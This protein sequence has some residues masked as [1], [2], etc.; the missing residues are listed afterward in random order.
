MSL[1]YFTKH[2]CLMLDIITVLIYLLTYFDAMK[3]QDFSII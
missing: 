2:Y 3:K 1:F